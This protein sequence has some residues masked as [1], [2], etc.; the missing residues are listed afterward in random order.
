GATT[1]GWGGGFDVGLA[2]TSAAARSEDGRG[3][4]TSLRRLVPAH[5][6]VGAP[7]ERAEAIHRGAISMSRLE[8]L[9]PV[10]FAAAADDAVAARIVERRAPV[11][12][13]LSAR[14]LRTRG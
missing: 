1:G 4:T 10:V 13:A 5:F 7:L 8:E 3:P 6:G 12:R 2:A 11:G 14:P 9:P